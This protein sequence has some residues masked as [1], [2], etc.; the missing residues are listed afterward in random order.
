MS[1]F[2]STFEHSMQVRSD[3]DADRAAEAIRSARRLARGDPFEV[4][5][6]GRFERHS[7]GQRSLLFAL[8]ADIARQI[9]FPGGGRADA[10]AW[11]DLL[12]G[13][14]RGERIARQGE[15]VV[16]VGGSTS[17]ATRSEMAEI[18]LFVESWGAERGVRFSAAAR[19]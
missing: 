16:I 19:A 5:I 14:H 1:G 15:V 11:R 3:A 17:G 12:V 18:I 10:R 9:E 2:S 4:R 13:L 8:C 7:D 6:A